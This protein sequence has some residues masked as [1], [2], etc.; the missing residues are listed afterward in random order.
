LRAALMLG[1]E[2]LP[3]LREMALRETGDESCTARA[4]EA[5]GPELGGET[6]HALLARALRERRHLL[7]RAAMVVLARVGDTEALRT[8]S[9][10]PAGERGDLAEAAAVALGGSNRAA[11]EAPLVAAL[12]HA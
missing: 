2:G 3:V 4:V 7:A 11:A 6:A 8:R 1:P 10:I 5:P 9:R 12:D